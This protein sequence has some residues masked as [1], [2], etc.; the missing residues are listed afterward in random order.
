MQM[1]FS[2][3]RPKN[4]VVPESKPLPSFFQTPQIRDRFLNVDVSIAN[5]GIAKGPVVNG[6]VSK[7]TKQAQ[8]YAGFSNIM[9]LVKASNVP[10]GSCGQR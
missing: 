5:D 6:V 8:I 7:E 2:V 4:Y 10:C 1:Q 3:N 9:A